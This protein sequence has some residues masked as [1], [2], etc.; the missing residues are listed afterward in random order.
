M[1]H[2]MARARAKDPGRMRAACDAPP[3][4]HQWQLLSLESHAMIDCPKCLRLA[5]REARQRLALETNRVRAI[6]ERVR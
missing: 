1:K 5:L 3:A 2:P 6:Q 4:E